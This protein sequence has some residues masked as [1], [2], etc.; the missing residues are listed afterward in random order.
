MRASLTRLARASQ[1]KMREMPMSQMGVQEYTPPIA[2]NA[3]LGA[4]LVGSVG[5]IYYFTMNRMQTQVSE[6]MAGPVFRP[7]AKRHVTFTVRRIQSLP[8]RRRC[9]NWTSMLLPKSLRLH[10]CPSQ[11]NSGASLRT[12]HVA[13]S[14]AA[15]AGDMPSVLPV[16][17]IAHHIEARANAMSNLSTAW[18]WARFSWISCSGVCTGRGKKP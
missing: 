5:G 13:F 9:R 15:A 8:F 14:A 4:L 11:R 3:A 6:Q 2:K 17:A 18:S 7:A 16:V 1:V 12:A 10:Q